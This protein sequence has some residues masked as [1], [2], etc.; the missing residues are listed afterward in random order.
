MAQAGAGDPLF[1]GAVHLGAPDH[2]LGSA[3][4]Y[5][6]V[7]TAT[8]PFED[9][10]LV[11]NVHSSYSVYTSDGKL[12][13]AVENH[14][15]RS[16]EIPEVVTLPVGSYVIEARSDRDGYVRVR[17]VINAGRQTILDLDSRGKESPRG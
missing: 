8:D 17:I 11:F 9:G 2:R 4:G 10:E 13:K 15:S 6:L 12:F 3:K 1:V 7:Y 14:M 5:L 16:D